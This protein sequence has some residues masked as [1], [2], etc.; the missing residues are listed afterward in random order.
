MKIAKRFAP[1]PKTGKRRK[2]GAGALSRHVERGPDGSPI[3]YDFDEKK[4]PLWKYTVRIKVD[5]EKKCRNIAALDDDD[6]RD[7]AALAIADL[8]KEAEAATRAA[9]QEAKAT[10]TRTVND[11]CDHLLKVKSADNCSTR[12]STVK[13][14]EHA[15]ERFIRH[16]PFSALRVVE[17]TPEHVDEWIVRHAS[18]KA[19]KSETRAKRVK[20]LNTL[21]RLAV[22]DGWRGT[23]PVLKR[24][25]VPVL[26]EG[27]ANGKIVGDQRA[28]KPLLI[29][30]IERVVAKLDPDDDALHLLVRLT[31]RCGFRLR[32]ATH[33]RLEDLE[34]YDDGAVFLRVVN[35]R[36]C[37]CR[38]CRANNGVRLNKASEDRLAAVPPDLVDACRAHANTLRARFGARSWFFP[39]W[40]AKPR[41]RARPGDIRDAYVLSGTFAAAAKKAELP[42]RVFHDLRGSAKRWLLTKVEANPTAV[43]V[44][45]GHRLPGMTQ[46]YVNY[47]DNPVELY[48]DLF[49]KLRPQP[50]LVKAAK[51]A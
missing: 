26:K 25:H 1:P 21:F 17:V 22:G 24:H 28:A 48:W 30:E 36:P 16:D 3:P 34:E 19:G 6:A 51:T 15:I 12:E 39:V 13:G 46:E 14:Y 49:R 9:K 45:L 35:N 27:R 11:L 41:Q 2:N 44:M 32:E 40:R 18:A 42:G 43:D 33:L 29:D 4:R 31:G 50:A 37:A 8:L 7:K 38:D 5:G 23:S 20:L 47:R 10:E